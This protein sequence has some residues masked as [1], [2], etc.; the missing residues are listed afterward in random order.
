MKA[1]LTRSKLSVH[2]TGRATSEIVEGYGMVRQTFKLPISNMTA[3][4]AYIARVFVAVVTV[5]D[6]TV[7]AM[8][9]CKHFRNVGNTFGK[10]L[11]GGRYNKAI[12]VSRRRRL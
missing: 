11:R 10:Q 6:H 8:H 7:Y 5:I 4:Y 9:S 2:M 3:H 1:L 12:G